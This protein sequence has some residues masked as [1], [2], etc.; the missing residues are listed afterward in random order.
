MGWEAENAMLISLLTSGELKKYKHTKERTIYETYK[1]G[2]H[3]C[4]NIIE[5]T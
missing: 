5:D 4:T 1:T 2:K 3:F